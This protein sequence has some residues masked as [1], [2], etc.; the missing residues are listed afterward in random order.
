M[1][2]LIYIISLPLS[3]YLLAG[4][5]QLIDQIDSEHRS[6]LL[7]SLVWRLFLLAVLLMV[8]PAG[9]RIWIGAA[10]LTVLALFLSAQYGF[11]RA[12]RSGR[13]ITERIE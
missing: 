9:L 8:T 2:F 1:A 12:I 4:C 3:V 6:R 11:R 13:W 7:M 5:L 10:A